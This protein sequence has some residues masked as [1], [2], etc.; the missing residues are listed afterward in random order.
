[1]D[2]HA[3]P[4][5]P[6]DTLD[7]E[8][9]HGTDRRSGHSRRTLAQALAHALGLA[10][11]DDGR[12]AQSSRP[13]APSLGE[14]EPDSA[15]WVLAG[16][17][18]C[19]RRARRLVRDQLGLWALRDRRGVADPLVA[20]LVSEA[21]RLAGGPV[22]LSLYLVDGTLRAEAE[23]ENGARGGADGV[24][25]PALERLACCWGRVHTATGV[26]VWAEFPSVS[27][28]CHARDTAPR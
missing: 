8:G 23:V 12:H 25:R 9:R 4:S 22:R 6:A 20:E 10:S 18:S 1:M 19:V 16:H 2:E 13:A 3:S 14:G 17:A 26:A 24:E 27:R 5:A 15:S 11:G 7:R 28:P 21:L